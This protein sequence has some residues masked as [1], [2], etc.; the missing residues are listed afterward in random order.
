MP[1]ELTR[2]K[3]RKISEIDFGMDEKVAIIGRVKEIKENSIIFQDNSGEVEIGFV[4]GIKENRLI[5]IFCS[6]VDGR[7]LVD[8]FQDLKEFDLDLWEEI[9]KLY[10]EANI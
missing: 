4:D 2:Y 8:F 10:K 9:N 5:R 3:P 1:F 7:L 6:V